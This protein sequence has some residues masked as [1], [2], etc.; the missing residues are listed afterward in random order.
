MADTGWVIPQTSGQGDFESGPPWVD[1]NNITNDN[2]ITT[3]YK[4]KEFIYIFIDK[5][6]IEVFETIK[7]V[8]ISD[9]GVFRRVKK[10]RLLYSLILTFKYFPYNITKI[11]KNAPFLRA[12]LFY[13]TSKTRFTDVI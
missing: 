2:T 11:A 3:H 1:P 13:G 6:P 9:F 8:L 12:I 5:K 10:R 7:N 4:N